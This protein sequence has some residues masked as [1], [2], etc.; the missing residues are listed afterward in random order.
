V[1]QLGVN[2]RMRIWEA[3]DS[4]LQGLQAEGGMPWASISRFARELIESGKIQGPYEAVIVDEIQDLSADDLKFLAALC[5]SPGNL[6][7]VGDA[8]QR[9]YGSSISLNKVGIEVRGRSH[10]LK[11]NYRTSEQIRKFADKILDHNIDDLDGGLEDRTKTKSLFGGPEPILKGFD[12]DEEQCDY[13]LNKIEALT[14]QGINHR[15]IAIFARTGK[16]LDPI[17]KALE[18]NSVPYFDLSKAEKGET[19]EGVNLGTM[20]RA[21]GLEF[22]VVFAIGCSKANLPLKSASVKIKDSVDQQDFLERE[23]NLLYVAITRARDEAFVLW[24]GNP[25]RFIADIAKALD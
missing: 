4:V 8:G 16:L 2:D 23:K 10:V 15:A 18:D 7:L 20:H 6:M 14:K 19:A 13:V 24:S 25:S 3:L 1:K 21:K 17:R 22:K 5:P 9:I 12:S 11:I